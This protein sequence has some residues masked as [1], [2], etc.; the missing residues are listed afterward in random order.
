MRSAR[1][2]EKRQAKLDDIDRQVADGSLTIRTLSDAEKRRFGIADPDKPYRRF[3]FP[4]AK[5]GSRRGEQLYQ[6]LSRSVRKTTGTLPKSRRIYRLDCK[7]D[8]A[9]VQ[10]TV[11]ETEPVGKDTVIAIFDLGDGKERF[12][13]CTDGTDEDPAFRLD[14]PEKGVLEFA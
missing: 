10:L 1:D 3:F 4:G 7:I 9:E 13:V 8:G 6:E 2:A 5:P 14:A 12:A 11:G